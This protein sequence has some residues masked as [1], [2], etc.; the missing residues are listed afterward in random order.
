MCL[1]CCLLC[2]PQ[3]RRHHEEEHRRVEEVD[4]QQQSASPRVRGAT[5]SAGWA[6]TGRLWLGMH[7]YYKTC[8]SVLIVYL[9]IQTLQRLYS[10]KVITGDSN[11][12]PQSVLS[13][14]TSASYAVTPVIC[15][16]MQPVLACIFGVHVYYSTPVLAPLLISQLSC[17]FLWHHRLFY[18]IFCTFR[19]QIRI[20][21]RGV[22]QLA[23][24][25]R[26]VYSTCSLNP[27]EDEAVIATL[28][29]K[30]EGENGTAASSRIIYFNPRKSWNKALL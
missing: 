11:S 15:V 8:I 26:M 28:L 16:Q 5:D 13:R 27:V 3:R 17:F 22:E 14:V 12:I 1:D 2:V 29:E 18:S 25:G 19:L 30:S 24:G 23:V 4:N 10:S 9:I 6:I 20:A 21:V 7:R